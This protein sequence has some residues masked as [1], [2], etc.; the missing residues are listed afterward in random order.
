MR[1]L[2]VGDLNPYSRTSQRFNALQDLGH[3]IVGI[4]TARSGFEPG[5]SPDIPI[6]EKVFEKIGYPIDPMAVNAK[7]ISES[8]SNYDIIWVEKGWMVRPS[9]LNILKKQTSSVLVF[10]SV[11]NLE[12]GH[13]QSKYMLRSLG[14]FDFVVTKNGYSET[15]FRNLGVQRLIKARMAHDKGF[16]KAIIKTKSPLRPAIFVG[17]Y[18]ESRFK[19]LEFLTEN[20]IPI[21]V[22]GNGWPVSP[23]ALFDIK[24]RPIYRDEFIKEI[25]RS[26]LVFNF[27]RKINDDTST[28]RTVEIPALG[29]FLFSETS[30]P[31]KRYFKDGE[32]AV[33]FSC[34]DLDDVLS[35][36]RYYLS[37][38]KQR[39]DI[40]RAG[41][42][43]CIESKYDHHT[44][45]E[46]ILSL[47]SSW[48]DGVASISLDK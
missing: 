14:L 15:F 11:D 37:N 43:R 13:N 3:E 4:N 26:K 10:F 40:A 45:L 44:S 7:I 24:R 20:G 30:E 8:V 27:L 42:R 32:E 35:K 46:G 12:K 21:T 17:S 18:E 23:N 41:R 47:L 22:F 25:H 16:L 31:Q 28:G 19:V 2:F 9:T 1:I 33:F 29:A 38:D 5:I 34:E 39:K 36:C 48:P 6:I